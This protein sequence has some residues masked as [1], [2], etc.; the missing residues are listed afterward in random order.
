MSAVRFRFPFFPALAAAVVV[1]FLA[2]VAADRVLRAPRKASQPAVQRAGPDVALIRRAW[3]IIDRQ[4]VDRSALDSA[5]L[6]AGA[7]TGMVDS[8]GDTGHSTYLTRAMVQ[9]ERSLMRGEYVGVGLEI[10]RKNDQVTIVAPLDGSPAMQAGLHAGEQLLRVNGRP[11]TG[12]S[13]GEIVNLIT[14]PSGTTVVLSLFDPASGTTSEVPLKRA[15]IKVDNVSWQPIPGYPIAD[16]RVAAFSRGVTKEVTAA[17]QKIEEMKLDAAVLD[18]RNNPGGEL[19]E[20][21]GIAS[22]FLSDGD[23]LLE[24]DA[25]GTITHDAVR[26]GGVATTLPIVVLINE[27]TASAA[28]IVAGALRDAGRAALVGETTF[29]T[30][31][32]LQ[33]FPLGDGSALLLA[34]REWLTPTGR[35]IWHTGIVPDASV[36]LPANAA[37]ITAATLKGMTPEALRASADLQM[38]KALELLASRR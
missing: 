12:L 26:R 15:R 8:L 13:L 24:E 7:I 28:E 36:A 27:G 10:S 31:T 18:L 32:V 35:T 4:Y 2:G 16:I 38:K 34:V 19:E 11:V 6:T 21:I 14:G 9:E 37:S 17:L 1:S 33:D 29:G 5:P 20:A 3:D 30:G 23:V 25:Q 22:Q